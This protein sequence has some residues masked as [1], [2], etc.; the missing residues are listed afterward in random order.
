M[1]AEALIGKALG[2]CLLQQVIGNGTMGVVYRAVQSQPFRSVAVKVF[3]RAATLEIQHQIEFLDRSRGVLSRVADLEHPH[4]VPVYEHGDIDGLAYVAMANIEGETLEEVLA[5]RGGRSGPGQLD[6]PQV[7]LYLE[8]IASAIDYAHAQGIIHRDLKPANIFITRDNQVFVA[9]F[10]LTSLLVDGTIAP[11]RLSRPGMLDYMSPELIIGKA[12]DARADIYS[13]G[14]MLFRMVTGSPLFQGQTLMKVATRHLKE[15]PPSP[16]ALRPDLPVAAE[17]AILKALE[18][19]PA[20]RF[21]YASDLALVFRQA[22]KNPT[23]RAFPTAITAQPQRPQVERQPAASTALAAEQTLASSSTD[24]LS[25]GKN[26]FADQAAPSS[27]V[28]AVATKLRIALEERRR[29]ATNA[30][31]TKPREEVNTGNIEPLTPQVPTLANAQV[32]HAARPHQVFHRS[33][34]AQVE[35]KLTRELL[36]YELTATAQ[37]NTGATG[38]LKLTL[39]ARLIS[40]PVAGQPG[41]YVTGILPKQPLQET[42]QEAFALAPSSH[43]PLPRK[44]IPGLALAAL[45]ILLGSLGIWFARS[46]MIHQTGQVRSGQTVVSGTPDLDAT[47]TERAMATLEANTILFD[48]LSQN[49]RNWPVITSGTLLYQFKD[50]AYHITNNDPSKIANAILPGESLNQPFA[51]SLTLE[52]IHGDDTSINN[53]FGMIVRFSSQQANGKQIVRFYSFEALNKKGGE[54]QFWKYDNSS[55]T[56]D[57]WKELAHR[58]FGGEF[59][60]GHGATAINVFKILVNGKNFTLIM[61]GKQVWS[62]SD[63]SLTGGSV[64]MLVN[65]KGTEV[66]FSNL[67]LTHN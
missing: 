56:G 30:V 23:R 9:D 5:R 4:I 14:A 48:P 41:Q 10:H 50:Q 2:S 33:Q 31:N 62:V 15:I 20:S 17:Q 18:K 36:P 42:G 45:L 24:A 13:L 65:L 60:Q 8:Q 22:I 34:R 19:N 55:A 38:T 64:G 29:A 57:P 11:M 49:I 26:I 32:D 47:A 37:E 25:F 40:I 3:T 53:E 6:L 52:E 63:S 44:K 16:R 51:Y 21:E 54:Y 27:P 28:P 58:S 39:P 43:A 7:L 67:R 12:V 35:R 66:A 1:D 46:T 61:N 59:H